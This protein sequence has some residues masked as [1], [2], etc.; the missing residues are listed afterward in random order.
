MKI[1]KN[2]LFS[3]FIV[4][5]INLRG[6]AIQ[7]K[8]EYLSKDMFIPVHPVKVLSTSVHEQFD[9][10]YFI[11]PTDMWID[12]FKIVPKNSIVKAQISMLKMPVTGVNAA[13]R[14]E[15]E[16]ITYPDGSK[17]KLKGTVSY[18]GERQ[19]GGNL[20]PPLSYNKALHPRKG[21]YYNGVVAQYVPSGEYEF[22]QHITIMPN[23]MLYI[24]LD[25]D[26]SPY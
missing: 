25:E 7:Y 22:G 15:T 1:L 26:F 2:I 24:I 23:E 4:F 21:E 9:T 19:I 16:D 13:M 14:I 5:F 3:I 11:V 20:T 12:E 8:S 6:Y 10:V 18:N 17:Y